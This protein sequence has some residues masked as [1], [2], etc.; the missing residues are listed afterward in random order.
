[1]NLTCFGDTDLATSY[2][3]I[4]DKLCCYNMIML[5]NGCYIVLNRLGRV[6]LEKL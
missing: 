5:D 4:I 1:M 2:I 3:Y 6:M